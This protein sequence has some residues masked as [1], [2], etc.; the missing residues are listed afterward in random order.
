MNSTNIA[1]RELFD[2]N[3]DCQFVDGDICLVDSKP[4]KNMLE[5][6]IKR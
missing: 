2:T 5:R 4:T 1:F 3:G 6:L